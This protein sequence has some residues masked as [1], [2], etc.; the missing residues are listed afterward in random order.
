MGIIRY[1]KSISGVAHP[2]RLSNKPFW[3]HGVH[4]ICIKERPLYVWLLFRSNH[5]QRLLLKP[6]ICSVL[7]RP[8]RTIHVT[9]T[10]RRDGSVSTVVVYDVGV[11]DG[12]A[13]VESRCALGGQMFDGR[14]CDAPLGNVDWR[15]GRE[16]ASHGSCTA[17]WDSF[18]RHRSA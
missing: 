9:C 15:P 1:V 3:M 2:P 4:E 12:A 13:V 6:M 17:L 11:A 14:C 16:V 7:P 8:A 10:R 18:L 5:Q